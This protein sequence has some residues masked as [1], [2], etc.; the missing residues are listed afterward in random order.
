MPCPTLDTLDD[1]TVLLFC[2]S[3]QWKGRRL[4]RTPPCATC[5]FRQETGEPPATIALAKA[6]FAEALGP[7][8][9]GPTGPTGPTGP[10][11]T[12]AEPRP[13][14]AAIA[15]TLP[16]AD[17]IKDAERTFQRPIFHADGSIEYP[18]RE[19]DWEP[20]QVPEG[21]V[22]DRTNKWKFLPLWPVCQLRNMTAFFKAACGCI[23]LAS[24]C[25][26]PQSPEFARRVAHTTCEA[27]P[28]R[29]P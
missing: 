28:V 19:K 1:G 3:P 25:N 26:S 15:L 13:D 8:T 2:H 17:P 12:V 16:A 27:C 9:Q 5:T 6:R 22:R 14:M 7:K 23:S 18:K 24:R 10:A 11:D 29:K 4:M 21:F 20:P